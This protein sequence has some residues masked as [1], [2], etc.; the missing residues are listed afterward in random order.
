MKP[1]DFTPFP[2]MKIFDATRFDQIGG[3]SETLTVNFVYI[4]YVLS[5]FSYSI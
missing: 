2:R 5:A 3:L 4:F 1:V